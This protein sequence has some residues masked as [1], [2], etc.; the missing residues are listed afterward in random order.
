[1]SAVLEKKYFDSE[2]TIVILLS[3]FFLICLAAVT[4]DIPFPM[5]TMCS[6]NSWLVVCI[7]VEAK[8][9]NLTTN[10]NLELF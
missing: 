5:M 8:V 4:P 7:S 2:E 6:I 9:K 1:M 3:E 10:Y